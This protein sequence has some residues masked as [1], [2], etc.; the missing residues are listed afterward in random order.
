MEGSGLTAFHDWLV[1]L[2]RHFHQYPEL[3]YQEEKTAARISEELETLGVPH[4]SGVGKTGIIAAVEAKNPGPTVAFRADM[5]AL[6]LEEANDVP[7][8]SKHAGVMHA[9]GHDGHI[10][11]ALGVARWLLEEGW[12]DKGRGRILLLFQPAE[13]GGAGARAML[14][15]GLLDREPIEA[16]FAGH[17]NP[18][19][20]VRQ[21][22]I[23]SSTSNAAS[24][25]IQIG[26]TGK[27]G[28]GAQPH[29]CIDP[30]IAGAHLMTQL[31]TIIS[32]S[33]SPLDSAVI[34]IGSF[35]AG[36]ASNII[37]QEAILKGTLRTIRPEVREAVVERMK[38]LLAGLEAAHRVSAD[39]TVTSGYPLLVNNA[40]LVEYCRKHA[41]KILGS[42]FVHRESPRMGAE[43]FAYFAQ[44]WPG[45][46]I[47]LGCRDTESD[48]THGLH[49][50]YFDF[51]ER[52][53]DMGVNLFGRLLTRFADHRAGQDG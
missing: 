21:I 34:S 7:Y 35:H 33:L 3:S 38:E 22:G 19:L 51:D 2:R 25:T 24:D 42:S 6:P 40:N 28:H 44:K 53:L 5:D 52:V 50:P 43:D 49:S 36:T 26:L 32:R 20:P 45:I 16:I 13:E 23:A 39:L 47:R 14:E 12:P 17:M 46:L 15:T 1:Q 37:P 27:G 48:F 29:L 4:K 41:K 18:E 8:K 31:Q 10:T 11:I 9:C 30:I